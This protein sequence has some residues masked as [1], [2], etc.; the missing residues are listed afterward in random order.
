MVVV[1]RA[2][3]RVVAVVLGGAVLLGVSGCTSEQD[4][5]AASIPTG[6]ASPTVAP[7]PSVDPTQAAI[8]KRSAQAAERYREYWDIVAEYATKG[9]SPLAQID[10]RGYIMG[11]FAEDEL[12]H[13]GTFESEGW[14]ETGT[15]EVVSVKTV[16]YEGDPQEAD[17]TGHRVHLQVC[18]DTSAWDLVGSDGESLL[19][20]EQGTRLMNVVLQGQPKK[21]IWS[22]RQ[23]ER[24]DGMTC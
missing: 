11:D 13:W 2:V 16:D 12:E 5:P 20:G 8:E 10:G 6:S 19:S 15:V 1:S 14:R 7:S 17:I 24:I 9:E 3:S 4:A 21:G 18:I 22:I 23:N